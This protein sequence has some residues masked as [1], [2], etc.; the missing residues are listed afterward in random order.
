MNITLSNY[1]FIDGQN[2]NLSI[3][4][5]G[6]KLNYA[7]FRVYLKD[8]YSIG[9][10]YYFI[11]YVPGNGELYKS[12]RINGYV[13]IFKPTMAQPD[14]SIKGNVDAE[15]VLHTMIELQNYDKAL[16]VT[17]DGDLS[18]LV[19]YL[20]KV[21]KLCEILSPNR[22]RCSHL[23]NIAAGNQIAYMDNLRQKLEYKKIC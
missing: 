19:R 10:A 13:L 20:K 21:D 11:G 18:C 15:L 4:A 5:M 7:R 16:I 9:T 1:A 22:S 12:L 14:G 3:Q 23:L 2:L 8:K 17:G 6:W